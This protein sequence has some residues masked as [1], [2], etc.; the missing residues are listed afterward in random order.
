MRIN[1][2]EIIFNWFN[3]L[4]HHVPA[5]IWLEFPRTNCCGSIR[6]KVQSVLVP[7]CPWLQET[8]FLLGNSCTACPVRPPPSVPL[9]LPVPHDVLRTDCCVVALAFGKHR[10]SA[11]QLRRASDCR[12]YDVAIAQ[13]VE[14]WWKHSHWL[15]RKLIG[16]IAGPD[17]NGPDTQRGCTQCKSRVTG[18][19]HVST[20]GTTSTGQNTGTFHGVG[21]GR[22]TAT[23]PETPGVRLRKQDLWK[24]RVI[25][26]RVEGTSGF[27]FKKASSAW[28][29]VSYHGNILRESNLLS[30]RFS[31]ANPEFLLLLS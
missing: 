11:Y 27:Q 26:L 28:Y 2:D 29:W 8:L 19:G 31:S 18:R 21:V 15:H 17:R 22:P 4:R 14:T 5:L 20:A 24:P 7:V 13:P 6:V 1:Q 3:Q 30:D 16:S 12:R 9:W 23:G 25:S 10:N